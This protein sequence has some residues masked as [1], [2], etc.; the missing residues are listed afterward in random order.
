MPVK[1]DFAS[2]MQVKIV[3]GR[4]ENCIASDKHKNNLKLAEGRRHLLSLQGTKFSFAY[5]YTGY[6]SKPVMHEF[7][8]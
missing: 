3:S 1:N 5:G 8:C 4:M 2:K 6:L 7:N